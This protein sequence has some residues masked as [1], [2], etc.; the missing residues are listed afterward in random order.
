VPLASHLRPITL[1]NTDY[2]LLTKVY[3][4]RLMQVLPTILHKS[5]LCSVRGR[6]IMQGAICLWS[7]AEFVRQRKRNRFLMNLDF[8]HAY[9]RVCLPYVDKVLEA[10]GFG[11]VFREVVATLH[12][13]ATASFLLHRFSRAFPIT[14]SVRQ[15]DPIAMLLYNIQLQPPSSG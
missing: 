3:V 6:N 4:A 14:F 13:G 7:T 1:L 15:G 12:R 10:V 5:Q 2:K 11:S 9:D 8:Y